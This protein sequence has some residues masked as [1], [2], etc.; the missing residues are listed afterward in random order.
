MAFFAGT[1]VSKQF[2]DSETAGRE[3]A[4]QALRT[5]GADKADIAIVL[6]STV[7]DQEAM[8][9]GV[10]S[11]LGD[12]PVV[13]CTTAGA[14]T[15]EGVEEQAVCVLALKS[16]EGYFV[17]LK[18]TGISKDM[19]G[20][21]KSM[22][23]QI[24]AA[25]RPSHMAFVFSD[26]L[27]GNG[28]ELVRGVLEIMGNDYRLAG[29]AA[30]DDMNFKKTY[31]YFNDEVLTDAA[32]G[33]GMTEDIWIAIGADHG[34][35]PIGNSRK[36][37]KAEGTKLIELDGKPAFEIYKDYFGSRA[38]EFKKALSLAAVSYPLGMKSPGIED[39]MI[40][41]PLAVQDDGSIV[42]GAEVIEGNDIYLMIG[43]TTSVLWAAEKTAHDLIARLPEEHRR[44]VFVSNCVARKILLGT[45]GGEEIALLKSISGP[46]AQIFGF[47]SYGQIAPLRKPAEDIN[48]CDPGFY[49]QSISISIF[50]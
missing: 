5:S 25:P 12:T 32:V 24:K 1:G 27:S 42:C 49:E 9:K 38:D 20:A 36:V 19:R 45:R 7:Y 17:P 2:Q 31:Q 10:R 22:G 41:V 47:Y 39:L 3:A 4:S 15:A 16:D 13:G 50:G 21:G 35:Q 37:T 30:A 28:T 46:Q 43:T 26:A 8:L 6:A 44:V 34:W 48:T 18:A 23:E 11:A 33:F 40:R 29:G 14:I